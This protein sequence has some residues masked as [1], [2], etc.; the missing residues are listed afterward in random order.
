MNATDPFST[1]EV[2]TLWEYWLPRLLVGI[3]SL[4]SFIATYSGLSGMIQGQDPGSLFVAFSLTLAIQLLIV[5][6]VIHVK[7]PIGLSKRAFW[8]TIYFVCV[9]FSVGFGYAFWFDLLRASDHAMDHFAAESHRVLGDFARVEQAYDGLN[10]IAENLAKH[11]E[12][13]AKDEKEKGNTCGRSAAGDGVVMRFRQEDQKTFEQF[14]DAFV[15]QRNAL[16]QSIED[17]RNQLTDVS[18]ENQRAKA[19][20][21]NEG[22]RKINAFRNDPLRS[23]FQERLIIR[24]E[25]GEQGIKREGK[26]AFK[27]PDGMIVSAKTT[28]LKMEFPQI[29]EVR[30]FDP[31]NRNASV[32]FAFSRLIELVQGLATGLNPLQQ[33]QAQVVPATANNRGD[34]RGVSPLDPNTLPLVFGLAVDLLLL[35]TANGFKPDR[36]SVVPPEGPS[37]PGVRAQFDVLDHYTY[38]RGGYH[39][40]VAPFP[41]QSEGDRAIHRLIEYFKYRDGVSEFLPYGEPAKCLESWW[42]NSRPEVASA[43]RI[44]IFLVRPEFQKDLLAQRFAGGG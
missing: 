43:E 17:L 32:N 9:F 8:L 24:V 35:L 31:A 36:P 33:A 19:D 21:I 7:S 11:S 10:D 20:A 38:A 40:L 39:Y 4:I 15:E 30:V 42:L 34:D 6:A 29:A 13:L 22:I 16:G 44:S 27:C 41:I 23:S 37:D 14:K 28:V 5:W 25:E 18:V 1:N 2:T 26:P 3:L 12:D